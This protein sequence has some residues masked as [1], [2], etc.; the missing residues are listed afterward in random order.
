MAKIKHLLFSKIARFT[1]SETNLMKKL[2]KQNIQPILLTS[3]DLD[4]FHNEF[5][6]KIKIKMPQPYSNA[7]ESLAINSQS[8]YLT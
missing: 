2:V 7:L 1:T 3:N 8:I 6:S 4:F 5:Y